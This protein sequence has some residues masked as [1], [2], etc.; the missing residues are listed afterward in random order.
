VI[1][2]VVYTIG[3]GEHTE[4]YRFEHRPGWKT[5]RLIGNSSKTSFYLQLF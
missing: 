5:W 4:Y 1:V 2:E 3:G